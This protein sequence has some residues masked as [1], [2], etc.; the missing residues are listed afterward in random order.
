MPDPSIPQ[1]GALPAATQPTPTTPEQTPTNDVLKSPEAFKVDFLGLMES[2]MQDPEEILFHKAVR[3]QELGK[4]I[5]FTLPDEKEIIKKYGETKAKAIQES[6]RQLSSLKLENNHKLYLQEK[7]SSTRNRVFSTELPKLD[8]GQWASVDKGVHWVNTPEEI[9]RSGNEMMDADGKIIKVWDYKPGAKTVEDVVDGDYWDNTRM[10]IATDKE[11]KII[12]DSEG[13]PLSRLISEKEHPAELP[14]GVYSTFAPKTIHSSNFLM[15]RVEDVNNFLVD[16]AD[17]VFSAGDFINHTTGILTNHNVAKSLWDDNARKSIKGHMNNDSTWKAAWNILTDYD[18]HSKDMEEIF[19]RGHQGLASRKMGLSE[20]REL[21]AFHNIN[22]F[23]SSVTDAV[24]QILVTLASGGMGGAGAKGLAWGASKLGAKQATVFSIGNSSA[25]AR[26]MAWGYSASMAYSGGANAAMGA[27]LTREEAHAFGGLATMA[28]LIAEKATGNQWIEKAVGSGKMDDYS[29]WISSEVKKLTPAQMKETLTNPIAQKNFIMRSLVKARGVYDGVEK[30]VKSNEYL[31]SGVKEGIQESLEEGTNLGAQELYDRKI[32][33]K[34]GGNFQLTWEKAMETMMESF[35]IGG[36]AGGIG[37]KINKM[38]TGG[39]GDNASQEMSLIEMIAKEKGNLTGFHSAL[40]KM[41]KQGLLGASELDAEGN[42]LREGKNSANTTTAESFRQQGEFLSQV[43]K[44]IR[45]NSPELHEKQVG[46]IMVEAFKNAQLN[47]VNPEDKKGLEN[48]GEKIS[49]QIHQE[50]MAASLAL[51][52]LKAD[53]MEAEKNALVEDPTRDIKKA[54][55]ALELMNERDLL[56]KEAKEFK[57][58][59]PKELAAGRS[60]EELQAEE[61]A[62]NE[63]V[64]DANNKISL[65]ME[66]DPTLASLADMKYRM[67]KLRGF[68]EGIR[69]GQRTQEYI[70]RSMLEMVLPLRGKLLE[71]VNLNTLEKDRDEYLLNEGLAQQTEKDKQDRLSRYAE[72]QGIVSTLDAD[73]IGENIDALE[74]ALAQTGVQDAEKEALYGFANELQGMVFMGDEVEGEYA[75]RIREALK[76]AP[77]FPDAAANP[78]LAHALRGGRDFQ[79]EINQMMEEAGIEPEDKEKQ[80]SYNEKEQAKYLLELLRDR[81]NM[82]MALHH[83]GRIDQ[84]NFQELDEQL[85]VDAINSIDTMSAKASQLFMLSAGKLEHI[86]AEDK[87]WMTGYITEK[88][89]WLRS[90]G[91]LLGIDSDEEIDAINEL[92]GNPAT[93]NEAAKQLFELEGTYH[94]ALLGLDKQAVAELMEGLNADKIHWNNYIQLDN[95]YALDKNNSLYSVYYLLQLARM[96]PASS[97]SSYYKVLQS[98]NMETDM[99]PSYEQTMLIR[100]AHAFMNGENTASSLIKS[101]LSDHFQS[102]YGDPVAKQ[103]KDQEGNMIPNHAYILT[104]DMFFLEGFGGTGKTTMVVSKLLELMA[105]EKG[106]LNVAYTAPGEEQLRELGKSMD[107]LSS[108]IDRTR[109]TKEQLFA[110]LKEA[111][112]NPA[113]LADIDVLVIDEIT[114]LAEGMG[115]SEITAL[116][117][118]LEIIN[119]R[120]VGGALRVLTLGDTGQLSGASDFLSAIAM[121]KGRAMT[122]VYRSGKVDAKQVQDFLRKINPN[123]P[124]I[125]TVNTNYSLDEKGNMDVGIRFHQSEEEVI[126]SFLRHISTV[127]SEDMRYV[128]GGD[129]AMMVERMEA[130]AEQNGIKLQNVDLQSRVIDAR[131]AQSQAFKHVYGSVDM[132][133]RLYKRQWHKAYLVII[134]REKGGS[135]SVYFPKQGPVSMQGKV[136]EY[137]KLVPRPEYNYEKLDLVKHFAGEAS[138]T[139]EKPRP[140]AKKKETKATE[141]EDDYSYSEDALSIF[142]DETTSEEEP[143]QAAE[144]ETVVAGNPEAKQEEEEIKETTINAAKETTSPQNGIPSPAMVAGETVVFREFTDGNTTTTVVVSDQNGGLHYRVF[145][146]NDNQDN[147]ERATNELV[148]RPETGSTMSSEQ[149][150][151]LSQRS[152]SQQDLKP[153]ENAGR[154]V[155]DLASPKESKTFAQ[156][157]KGL[158]SVYTNIIPGVSSANANARVKQFN[159]GLKSLY[160][161]NKAAFKEDGLLNIPASEFAKHFDFKGD[162]LRFVVEQTATTIPSMDGTPVRKPIMVYLERNGGARETDRFYIGALSERSGRMTSVPQFEAFAQR[163]KESNGRMSMDTVPLQHIDF[164]FHSE[165]K[166]PD[167]VKSLKDAEGYW[168]ERGYEVSKVYLSTAPAEQ[169]MQ[170]AV[171]NYAGKAFVLVSPVLTAKELDQIA[172]AKKGSGTFEDLTGKHSY[173]VVQLKNGQLEPS[174]LIDSLER[175]DWQE[176]KSK[177]FHPNRWGTLAKQIGIADKYPSFSRIP[178]FSNEFQAPYILHKMVDTMPAMVEYLNKQQDPQ[179]RKEAAEFMQYFISEGPLKFFYHLGFDGDQIILSEDAL[180]NE[181]N[182]LQKSFTAEER[183]NIGAYNKAIDLAATLSIVEG[184]SQVKDADYVSRKT[185]EENGIAFLQMA[186]IEQNLGKEKASEVRKMLS[187]RYSIN[188]QNPAVQVRNS[189]GEHTDLY[190]AISEVLPEADTFM[191]SGGFTFRSTDFLAYMHLLAH[192]MKQDKKLA[193]K[194]NNAKVKVNGRQ[195][196]WTYNFRRESREV[197]GV[198]AALGNKGDNGRAFAWEKAEI[199]G[200]L[201]VRIPHVVLDYTRI[202]DEGKPLLEGTVIQAATQSAVPEGSNP[203]VP[204]ITKGATF[205]W[206][207]KPFRVLKINEDGSVKLKGDVPLEGDNFVDGNI[208]WQQGTDHT[209]PSESGNPFNKMASTQTLYEDVPQEQVADYFKEFFGT[210]FYQ[211]YVEFRPDLFQDG[212]AVLGMVYKRM[213]TLNTKGEGNA[214]KVARHEAMHFVLDYF[215]DKGFRSKVLSEAM[216]T[217][218]SRKSLKNKYGEPSEDAAHELLADLHEGYSENNYPEWVPSPIRKL[219]HFL[220][221]AWVRMRYGKGVKELM[222]NIEGRRFYNTRPAFDWS[223]GASHLKVSRNKA[224][225]ALLDNLRY[226]GNERHLT[227]MLDIFRRLVYQEMYQNIDLNK[228]PMSLQFAISNL[229]GQMENSFDL[230]SDEVASGMA[231]FDNLSQQEVLDLMEGTGEKASKYKAYVM[232]RLSE[233]LTNYAFRHHEME[234]QY[235]QEYDSETKEVSNVRRAQFSVEQA[236]LDQLKSQSQHV[237]EHVFSTPLL[238]YEYG[239]LS[240]DQNALVEASWAKTVMVKASRLAR[241]EGDLSYEGFRKG[242][243]KLIATTKLKERDH[244]ISLYMKFFADLNEEVIPGVATVNGRF[245]YFN[246]AKDVE[247]ISFHNIASGAL[248]LDGEGNPV[249][250][251]A[252]NYAIRYNSIVNAVVSDFLSIAPKEYMVG[253]FGEEDTDSS[254]KEESADF[255]KRSK[256]QLK[257][258]ITDAMF[259]VSDEEILYRQDFATYLNYLGSIGFDATGNKL[260]RLSNGTTVSMREYD[261]SKGAYQQLTSNVLK[262]LGLNISVAQIEGLLEDEDA[263]AVSRE[264]TE[265]IF[266]TFAVNSLNQEIRE[267]DGTAIAKAFPYLQMEKVSSL[268]RKDDEQMLSDRSFHTLTSGITNIEALASV[269]G[270]EIG[271]PPISERFYNAKGEPVNVMTMS[272]ALLDLVPALASYDRW[273]EGKE[274]KQT[275]VKNEFYSN[276]LLAEGVLGKTK[277][278]SHVENKETGKS[279]DYEDFT[280][281]DMAFA[282]LESMFF[283]E[284]TANEQGRFGGYY[285][286]YATKSDKGQMVTQHILKDIRWNSENLSKAAELIDRSQ[287]SHAAAS[288]MRWKKAFPGLALKADFSQKGSTGEMRAA[289]LADFKSI[290]T[291]IKDK[292]LDKYKLAQSGLIETLDYDAKALRVNMLMYYDAQSTPSDIQK[293]LKEELKVFVQKL[294]ATNF[295]LSDKAANYERYRSSGFEEGSIYK[296]NGFEDF[297]TE[298]VH[299]AIVEAFYTQTINQYFLEEATAGAYYQFKYKTAIKDQASYEI[300]KQEAFIE[301]VKRGTEPIAP[302]RKKVIGNPYSMGA[303][304]NEVVIEDIKEYYDESGNAVSFKTGED[305]DA[306]DGIQFMN[307][308]TRLMEHFSYGG[309]K[310]VGVKAFMKP[311]AGGVSLNRLQNQGIATVSKYYNKLGTQVM[312]NSLMSKSP[313]YRRLNAMMMLGKDPEVGQILYKKY[314][315]FEKAG[316]DKNGLGPF[317]RLHK[318]LSE[319]NQVDATTGK[320]LRDT[321]KDN[322]IHYATFKSGKKVGT[323]YYYTMEDLMARYEGIEKQYAPAGSEQGE[324]SPEAQLER[325]KGQKTLKV[326]QVNTMESQEIGVQL[327]LTHGT[328]ENEAALVTQALYIAGLGNNNHHAANRIYEAVAGMAKAEMALMQKEQEDKGGLSN[329]LKEKFSAMQ[330]NM[331][332][333]SLVGQ[334]ARSKKHQGLNLPIIDSGAQGV[335]SSELSKRMIVPR[336]KGTKMVLAPATNFLPV[337]EAQGKLYLADE[338][339]E[340]IEVSQR[341]LRYMQGNGASSATFTEI[342]AANYYAKE[343]GLSG[344]ESLRQIFAL[345]GLDLEAADYDTLRSP[346]HASAVMQTVMNTDIELLKQMPL[347]RILRGEQ[348]ETL[349][350]QKLADR[351]LKFNSTLYHFSTRIPSTGKNSSTPSRTVAFVNDVDNIAFVPARMLK[352]QGSDFDGDGMTVWMPEISFSENDPA[353]QELMGLKNQV[354]DSMIAILRDPKNWA[355]LNREIS[356]DQFEA[357]KKKLDETSSE[358]LGWLSLGSDFTIARENMA[359]KSLVGLG[360]NGFKKYS[361]SLQ[362]E[363]LDMEK[364]NP[365]LFPALIRLQ[366]QAMSNP[367]AVASL[368]EQAITL[369]EGRNKKLSFAGMSLG[370]KVGYPSGNMSEL[371]GYDRTGEQ[372]IAVMYE[373]LINAFV[374]NAKHLYA[375]KL[376]ITTDSYGFIEYLMERG[377]PSDMLLSLFSHP[378]VRELFEA[379]T[380]NKSVLKFGNSDPKRYF[381]GQLRQRAYAFT[382][383]IDQNL[384]FPDNKEAYISWVR[385][386]ESKEDIKA[387][388]EMA[389]AKGAQEGVLDPA[390]REF[391]DY[392]VVLLSDVARRMGASQKVGQLLGITQGLETT[393]FDQHRQQR[394][395]YDVFG[396]FPSKAAESTV[397]E[398]EQLGML[399]DLIE[400]GLEIEAFA[401]ENG[402]SEEMTDLLSRLMDRNTMPYKM[403]RE[404][405][406]LR[407]Y[408]QAFVYDQKLRGEVFIKQIPGVSSRFYDFISKRISPFFV[409]SKQ[410]YNNIMRKWDHYLAGRFIASEIS[411]DGAQHSIRQIGEET[412][413]LRKPFDLMAFVRDFY[414]QM[415]QLRQQGDQGREALNILSFQNERIYIDRSHQMDEEQKA[416]IQSA[417]SMLPKEVQ[418]NL[419]YYSLV[420]EGMRLGTFSLSEFIPAEFYVQYSEFLETEHNRLAKDE[421]QVDEAMTDF[422]DKLSQTSLYTQM[423]KPINAIAGAKQGDIPLSELKAEYEISFGKQ[424]KEDKDDSLNELD[425]NEQAVEE[426][427]VKDF[428]D[429]ERGRGI[430]RAV[431]RDEQGN[432]EYHI[433]MTRRDTKVVGEELKPVSVAVMHSENTSRRYMPMGQHQG[434]PVQGRTKRVPNISA[435]QADLLRQGKPIELSLAQAKAVYKEEVVLL[436]FNI[437]GILKDNKVTPAGSADQK[438]QK[439]S[440]VGKKMS[441]AIIKEQV[442]Q[443]QKAF[444]GIEVRFLNNKNTPNGTVLGWVESGVVHI[445]LDQASLDTAFHEFG[446]IYLAAIKQENYENYLNIVESVKGSS[447]LKQLEKDYSELR[448]QEDLLEEAFVSLLGLEAAGQ[449]V[450]QWTRPSG[451]SRFASAVAGF[452]DSISRILNKVFGSSFATNRLA[453]IDTRELLRVMAAKMQS[454]EMIS[455]AMS[456]E[457]SERMIRFQKYRQA[458]VKIAAAG[459]LE[460]LFRD[461]Q[462]EVKGEKDIREYVKNK[463]SNK[464]FGFEENGVRYFTDMAG[465]KVVVNEANLTTYAKALFDTRN[466]IADLLAEYANSGRDQEILK[467]IFPSESSRELKGKKL[468]AFLDNGDGYTTLSYNKKS[469]EELGIWDEAFKD[470]NILIQHKE[471]DGKKHYRLF[472]PTTERLLNHNG[473]QYLDSLFEKRNKKK[474]VTLRNTLE[475]VKKIKGALFAM[476]LQQKAAGNA[477]VESMTL[478]DFH[479]GS[480]QARGGGFI[481]ADVFPSLKGLMQV[482]GFKDALGEGR[483]KSLL[484]DPSLYEEA[485]YQ[486][487]YLDMLLSFVD[488]RNPDH[489]EIAQLGREY[490]DNALEYTATVA[491][492]SVL[493]DKLIE[494]IGKIS[495]DFSGDLKALKVHSEYNL[496]VNTLDEIQQLRHGKNN[497]LT[498]RQHSMGTFESVLH[499]Q[500][501]LHNAQLNRVFGFIR[502]MFD[503]IK[504][505]F[506]SYKETANVVFDEYMTEFYRHN[507]YSL[508][509]YTIEDAGRYFKDLFIFREIEVED[510]QGNRKKIQFNTMQLK[511]EDELKHDYQKKMV[512]FMN[513]KM[514]EMVE[515]W[516]NRHPG[517]TVQREPGMLPF[518]KTTF[519]RKLGQGE[520][521]GAMGAFID[522][523]TNYENLY[524]DNEQSMLRDNPMGFLSQFGNNHEFGTDLRMSAM[525]ITERNGGFFISNEEQAGLAETNLEV[526]LDMFMYTSI[527]NQ[528]VPAMVAVKQ[529]ADLILELEDGM[530]DVSRT[531][532]ISYLNDVFNYLVYNEMKTIKAFGGDDTDFDRMLRHL[533]GA[534]SIMALGGNLPSA[535]SEAVSSVLSLSI[536]GASGYFGKDFFGA[537]DVTRAGAAV[538]KAILDR[539]EWRKYNAILDSMQMFDSDNFS[540]THSVRKKKTQKSLFDSEYTMAPYHEVD[541][542]SSMILTIAQLKKDG[543]LG[544]YSM[545]TK[546]V[547]GVEV[548]YLH[549]DIQQEVRDIKNPDFKGKKRE[550]ATVQKIQETNALMQSE[551]G[552]EFA[553][554]YDEVMMTSLKAIKTRLTGTMTDET[555][556]KI[557][558]NSMLALFTTFKRHI[559]QAGNR[560][561]KVGGENQNIRYYKTEKRKVKQSDG[562]F[563][564]VDVAVAVN[565]YEEGIVQTL[566]QFRREVQ[567]AGSAFN[568]AAYGKAWTELRPEQK[569]NF[570]KMGVD[571]GM[572]TL[573]ILALAAADDEEMTTG[574]RLAKNAVRD[575]LSTYN[576]AGYVDATGGAVPLIKLGQMFKSVG[577]MITGDVQKGSTEIAKSFGVLRMGMDLVK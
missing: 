530:E 122:R 497:R 562:S 307:G 121:E 436:P 486:E 186:K 538:G 338:L 549:Y 322:M 83:M 120:R 108:S 327:E 313:V 402:L 20:E 43:Y 26:T 228:T 110:K 423:L 280:F 79:S 355:E 394:K 86:E 270:S 481:L 128:Y 507:G 117:R 78:L 456:G 57:N 292:G 16:T 93:V 319:Q 415:Q 487:S 193:G 349:L 242:L 144:Q 177:G 172:E 261:L 53:L 506:N 395:I 430:Y 46:G 518:I 210:E 388:Q 310:G 454:G 223:D 334:I 420:T 272:N 342:I 472:F 417:V 246:G 465:E 401:K 254:V 1:N 330:T 320:A 66:E 113:I 34:A 146:G 500:T 298:N 157:S 416:G 21:G 309:D 15:S 184:V 149:L 386:S 84:E 451:K 428:S 166:L 135:A 63:K 559:L 268:M 37:E 495:N 74:A 88:L 131:A 575:T 535:A 105:I 547:E 429:F 94:E 142:E 282:A 378:Q 198:R 231:E 539:A 114:L 494:R 6:Y 174:D 329:W 237:K 141:A 357:K 155:V 219:L 225:E 421:K 544:Y 521:R 229:E 221:G 449:N 160:K 203:A 553:R 85:Y 290:D 87:R 489:E 252:F 217:I 346:E 304:T 384:I 485:A 227:R 218:S 286:K 123:N 23:S 256:Q 359:G 124:Q 389:Y 462:R 431:S 72:V 183:K 412:Y 22:N 446:H 52:N 235:V 8:A 463:M 561:Y 118:S 283:Q 406:H 71:R 437:L 533:K 264:I 188:G 542:M 266:N 138:T 132:D 525:G 360:A 418:Q 5:S 444:P 204:A 345:G 424:E 9:S 365:E 413:D 170:G 175:K 387:F 393:P 372:P 490:R 182:H 503:G 362:A 196:G 215:L 466:H 59:F 371:F 189:K 29:K 546:K 251:N 69:K 375:G 151:D 554:P 102:P 31:E 232:L 226:F 523:Y 28:M 541:R 448:S 161:A 91:K 400:S 224:A 192:G 442:A 32:S 90:F 164:P 516:N 305:V 426:T 576:L 353:E 515:D 181:G 381:M 568:P 558:T 230:D 100:Q 75:N 571:V 248:L 385:S 106:A 317:D 271:L 499:A 333:F 299:P 209:L 126:L 45:K 354:M 343:F 38:A 234:K 467:R 409:N 390:S 244:A 432:R 70:N 281:Y 201:D 73:T 279:A 3:E 364:N 58:S 316:T 524:L 438:K 534:S 289:V 202:S 96:N 259:I 14:F 509:D 510:E 303:I 335:L 567:E 199:S 458:N 17:V 136:V 440:L 328:E 563:R 267:I 176:Q 543:L 302:I 98:M 194:F 369:I 269:L 470:E 109:W 7:F 555:K 308:L 315:E 293:R 498:N 67:Q 239:E 76:T 457:L 82:L 573:L 104:D 566:N 39:K 414:A 150:R 152:D 459:E 180:K 350:R 447:I 484:E 11:G 477:I 347:A 531:E 97:L 374:D 439:A 314:L 19:N 410:E 140:V 139:E 274:L 565:R 326:P 332:N 77:G 445:N 520:Y 504:T 179:L 358:K 441:A 260:L 81:K 60:L 491:D 247:Q 361:Y 475:D 427:E 474:G 476:H 162:D 464:E 42:P 340:G 273:L 471:K 408:I 478:G 297:S 425:E 450:D 422:F 116:R 206:E 233:S 433:Y 517:R 129:V 564:E 496:L 284:V 352:I 493:E 419:F 171:H 505:S 65:A 55:D 513:K 145:N 220:K 366:Q 159:S 435:A 214:V 405:P 396:L 508:K 154:T 80:E 529:S 187:E 479:T 379:A 169:E 570:K 148:S 36:V 10:T 156:A 99:V 54:E 560:W 452:M 253:M 33:E 434:A 50:S 127:P 545:R 41:E 391:S 191:S 24:G 245:T 197:G 376:N 453:S 143:E 185:N 336:V 111:E 356:L 367:E 291:F 243:R 469:A 403:L 339:P 488:E 27:G 492:M 331:G 275:T 377:A 337:Y 163:L 258:R 249:N 101:Y 62:M 311:K 368:R 30:L 178:E 397:T 296:G 207:G 483:L 548:E 133:N 519:G 461:G 44:Q 550:L 48:I 167:N 277:I 540:L 528:K 265:L 276:P 511:G 556:G 49:F 92:S 211:N 112:D 95:P 68:Q 257:D 119:A 351:I 125:G 278:F 370:S 40:A 147:I 382:R 61:K 323:S 241:Q 468:E 557:E 12:K 532:E 363:L 398:S 407:Q 205:L 399:V 35:V 137:E 115:Q 4:E 312:T 411:L 262:Q 455:S 569:D 324:G 295:K 321:L 103:V 222:D 2:G 537:I 165:L 153:N 527:K 536:A 480:E 200:G 344:K 212:A 195:V 318:W 325:L 552:V 285:Q 373:R 238:R 574:E 502:R 404:L 18:V 473:L 348:D 482:K 383:G 130:L 577:L 250:G 526:L 522:K 168:G 64:A 380:K 47:D 512:R 300:A 301:S 306:T 294:E 341:E 255:D 392:Y 25:M 216:K 134:S 443:L 288:I 173:R 240:R 287:L 158:I 572:A 56:A 460:S 89:D 13:R 190:K 501:D 213:I 551:L 514:D 208:L 107:E 51:K 263:S 236:K